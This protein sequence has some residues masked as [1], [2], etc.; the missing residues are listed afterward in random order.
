MKF[1]LYI[2]IGL[3]AM[4][5][6]FAGELVNISMYRESFSSEETVQVDLEFYGVLD[7]DL[8]YS[9]INI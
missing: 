9:S 1:L 6:V 7:E 3:F 5:Y 4:N 2:L 8:S